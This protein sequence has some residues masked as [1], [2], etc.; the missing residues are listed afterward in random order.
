MGFDDT[1]E[2]SAKAAEI[3]NVSDISSKSVS[4]VPV[5]RAG[6]SSAEVNQVGN[7]FTDREILRHS[8]CSSGL[9]AGTW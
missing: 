3:H 7:C 2:V 6:V 1:K 8:P 9:C 5:E 4:G